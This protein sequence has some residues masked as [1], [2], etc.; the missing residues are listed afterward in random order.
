MSTRQ[1]LPDLDRLGKP[2]RR[3]HVGRTRIEDQRACQHM[4]LD[5]YEWDPIR[6]YGPDY[7]MIRKCR[8]CGYV[9]KW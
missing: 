2:T 4:W 8:F 3:G 6:D 9:E 7:A 5:D 1:G